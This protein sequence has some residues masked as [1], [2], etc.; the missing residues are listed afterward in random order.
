MRL[1]ARLA[2]HSASRCLWLFPDFFVVHLTCS[3]EVS[4][5]LEN[6]IARHYVAARLWGQLP[7]DNHRNLTS[8]LEVADELTWL[9]I[10]YPCG[11]HISSSA[12]A[13]E[14]QASTNGYGEGG[15]LLPIQHGNRG[16]KLTIPQWQVLLGA[17]ATSPGLDDDGHRVLMASP[18]T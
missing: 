16:G 10:G 14:E 4:G 13:D 2:W 1:P 12:S 18:A 15:G 6:A 5:H 9:G 17:P 11:D 3:Q 7:S 8:R